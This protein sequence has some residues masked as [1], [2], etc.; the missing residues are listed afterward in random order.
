[1]IN[2]ELYLILQKLVLVKNVGVVHMVKKYTISIACLFFVTV[3]E[4]VESTLKIENYTDK[5]L[6]IEQTKRVLVLADGTRLADPVILSD[7]VGFVGAYPPFIN[8]AKPVPFDWIARGIAWERFEYRIIPQKPSAGFPL[9]MLLECGSGWSFVLVES[10]KSGGSWQNLKERQPAQVSGTNNL[11]V[12][13]GATVLTVDPPGQEKMQIGPRTTCKLTCLIENGIQNY[14]LSLADDGDPNFYLQQLREP[15]LTSIVVENK[16]NIDWRV[17]IDTGT[18]A[19][20][21]QLF[22]PQYDLIKLAAF[23]VFTDEN[24]I[25]VSFVPLKGSQKGSVPQKTFYMIFKALN[26]RSPS[27]LVGPTPYRT[28]PSLFVPGIFIQTSKNQDFWHYTLTMDA[29][30][31]TKAK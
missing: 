23:P 30:S 22:F 16:T 2:P 14:L 21:R 15:G 13:A 18:S 26:S 11:W 10:G 31:D 12:K 5:L 20:K 27:V 8:R 19:Q 17:T 28:S 3:L 1:M 24:S 6:K 4:A 25:T 29:G 7:G 9:Y